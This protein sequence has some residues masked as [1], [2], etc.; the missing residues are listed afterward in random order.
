MLAFLPILS[1][2]SIFP[3]LDPPVPTWP[4]YGT[5]RNTL[6]IGTETKSGAVTQVIQDN[7]REAGIAFLN[8]EAWTTS[9]NN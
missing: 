3:R 8:S 5:A 2:C 4:K 9:V 7:Y 6:Q 1:F